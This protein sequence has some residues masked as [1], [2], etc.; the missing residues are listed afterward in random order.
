[1]YQ[2]T[3]KYLLNLKKEE[4]K[5]LFQYYWSGFCFCREAHFIKALVPIQK[6]TVTS[7]DKGSKYN[8]QKNN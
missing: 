5:R 3:Q 2:N 1:M 6:R 8:F 7:D 4:M